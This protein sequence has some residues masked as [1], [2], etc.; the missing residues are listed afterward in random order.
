MALTAKKPE[1]EDF[2]QISEGVKIAICFGLYDIGTQY[3]EKWDKHSRKVIVVWEIPEERITIDDKDLPRAI[4]QKYTLS[5]HE[6]ALLRKHLE[7]WR[8]KAFTE[9]ELD[10]FDLKNILGKACQLQI[11]HNKKD[12]KTYANISAIM[13]LPKGIQAP[14]AE[15]PLKF[16]AFE[17]GIDIPENTPKWIA[18]LIKQSTEY[19]GIHGETPEE[20]T[21][22]EPF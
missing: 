19:K 8:G 6:K 7:A 14:E 18:D 5:L 9:A 12:N 11:I 15:N 3:D 13:A 22:M 2:E 1:G 16:F 10:G 17:E 21:E 20:Y 4:S